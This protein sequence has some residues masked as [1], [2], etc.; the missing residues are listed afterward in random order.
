[1]S[2]STGKDWTVLNY[3]KKDS[4]NTAKCNV[5]D[6]VLCCKGASTSGLSRHLDAKHGIKREAKSCSTGMSSQ[7]PPT[8]RQT[9]I[10]V[11]FNKV[12]KKRTLDE[13]IARL[14]AEDGL[15]FRQIHNS[16]FI[17]RALEKDGY[18]FPKMKTVSKIVFGDCM[19]WLERQ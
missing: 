13:T 18:R 14:A 19:T 11:S 15:S 17:R 2:S 10:L 9:T 6:K 7:S 16:E 4:L 8:K 5:C 1:M 12:C 3:F